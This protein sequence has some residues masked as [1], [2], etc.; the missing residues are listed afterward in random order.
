MDRHQED[1]SIDQHG[2]PPAKGTVHALLDLIA[3]GSVLL[4]IDSLPGSYSNYTHLVDARSAEGSVFR[5]VVRRYAVFGTYDRGEKARREFET[6]E[7]LQENGVPAPQP[8]FLDEDGSTLGI[9]G[10]VTSYVSGRQIHTPPDPI[11]WAR[12]LATMLARIHQVP[13]DVEAM[14]FLLDANAEASWFLRSGAVPD[15]MNAHP[16]GAAVWQMVHDLWPNRQRVAGSLVHID[17]WSGNILWDQ[18]RIAAVVDWEEA[19]H[20]DPGIDVAYCRMD[21][22][23]SDLGPAADE[24]L[25][26]YEAG[27]GRSVPNLGLW[28]L[29]AAARPMF[30]ADGWVSE[31]PGRERFRRFIAQAMTRAAN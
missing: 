15:Y 25:E 6:L 7:L 23:L 5:I 9:P 13:C 24:F 16:D 18:D 12:A 1:N 22:F 2:G 21:M 14:S 8:L 30:H 28:E 20:G 10:I 29:V 4:A 3:P 27:V 11:S 26:A 17:Y 31:S 19:A